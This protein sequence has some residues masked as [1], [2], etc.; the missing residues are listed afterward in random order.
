MHVENIH[1]IK[2]QNYGTQ[3]S[4]LLNTNTLA[5]ESLEAGRLFVGSIIIHLLYSYLLP[6]HLLPAAEE[7][8]HT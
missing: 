2:Q 5:Q 4:M 6:G 7:E 1:R 8:Y 3:T